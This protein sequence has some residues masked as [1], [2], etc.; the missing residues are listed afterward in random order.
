MVINKSTLKEE[1]TN[2]IALNPNLDY[3]NQLFIYENK[4]SNIIYIRLSKTKAPYGL[5]CK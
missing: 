1:N 4:L 2:K 5:N 3:N